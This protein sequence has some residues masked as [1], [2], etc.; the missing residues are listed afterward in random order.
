MNSHA[1]HRWLAKATLL[2]ISSSPPQQEEVFTVKVN[3]TKPIW[4]Y[5]TQKQHCKGG[6]VGVVNAPQGKTVDDY[7]KAAAATDGTAGAGAMMFGGTMGKAGSSSSP[8]S[9]GGS[10]PSDKP[11]AAAGFQATGA[12]VLIAA[13]GL[14]VFGMM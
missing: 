2:T 12:G 9:A 10:S 6:M 4:F 3:D 8:S 5:C 7:K 1:R 11:S 13:A 14:A